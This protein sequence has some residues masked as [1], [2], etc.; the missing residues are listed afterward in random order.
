MH[1]LLGQLGLRSPAALANAD[2]RNNVLP[3]GVTFSRASGGTYFNSSGTLVEVGTNVPRFD[4]TLSGAPLGLLIES[5]AT[6]LVP[7][8]RGENA[9]TGVLGAGGALPTWWANPNNVTGITLEVITPNAVRFGIPGV[10]LRLFG[11]AANSGTY[12]IRCHHV[13]VLTGIATITF[14]AY[15]RREVSSGFTPQTQWC[16][17]TQAE[18]PPVLNPVPAINQLVLG[19]L[20]IEYTS[21]QDRVTTLWIPLDAGNSIDETFF[22]GAPQMAA[23]NAPSSRIFPPS[24]SPA[25]STRAAETVTLAAANGTYDVLVQ[26]TAGGEWRAGEVVTGGSYTITPRSG[27]RH[28]RRV[29]LYAPGTAAAYPQ[30]S[31]AA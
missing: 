16:I 25:T 31:V 4:H 18:L 13:T 20:T 15:L 12:R 11:T 2:F 3:P 14:S 6:N 8:S 1:W 19:A 28:V 9:V 10:V 29:R 5:S 26:D 30:W 21:S 27:Q 22:F 17:G 23:E 7:N 24:G